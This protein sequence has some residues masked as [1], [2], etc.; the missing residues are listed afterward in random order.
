MCL[1]D[2]DGN[3][4]LLLPIC[5]TDYCEESHVYVYSNSQ[6]DTCTLIILHLVFSLQENYGQPGVCQVSSR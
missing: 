3:I 6:V 5:T 4:D 2:G 1:P